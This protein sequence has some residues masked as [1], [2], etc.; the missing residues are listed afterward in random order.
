MAVRSSP[1]NKVDWKST[2]YEGRGGGGS[3]VAMFPVR[4]ERGTGTG[5]ESRGLEKIGY[6]EGIHL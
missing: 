1:G 4:W 2:V 3:I 5:D 6:S